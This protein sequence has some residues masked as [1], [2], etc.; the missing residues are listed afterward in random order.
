MENLLVFMLSLPVVLMF[1][2]F[3]EIIGMKRWINKNAD[4]LERRFPRLGAGVITH[5]QQTST[6]AF[7]AGVACV[8]FCITGVTFYAVLSGYYMLWMGAFT[9][10]SL[11]ILIHI[12]QWMLVRKYVPV[13]ITSVLVLPYCIYGL[14]L[15]FERFPIHEIVLWTLV[16]IFVAVSILLFVHKVVF[17]M[18]WLNE[19]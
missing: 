6:S 14:M 4:D 8:F 13:I 17:R 15:I 1:H 9:T 10:F 16:G 7:A 3:E 19:Y 11:H 18:K 2:D 5:F 12:V